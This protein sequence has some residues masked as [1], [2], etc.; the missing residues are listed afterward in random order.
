[1]ICDS[2]SARS[3]LTA[4]VKNTKATRVENSWE[5]RP[6]GWITAATK[7]TLNINW[8]MDSGLS[9]KWNS[10][11]IGRYLSHGKKFPFIWRVSLFWINSGWGK[12]CHIAG[13][14][15]GSPVGSKCRM[16]WTESWSSTWR[17]WKRTGQRFWMRYIEKKTQSINEP[18]FS[19]KTSFDIFFSLFKKWWN[20]WIKYCFKFGIRFSTS[21]ARKKRQNYHDDTPFK[22][23]NDKRNFKR[24]GNVT[25]SRY[26]TKT[27]R[28]A[29]KFKRS[30]LEL[31]LRLH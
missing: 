4:S 10:C 29:I 20:F 18:I 9:R 16:K 30:T 5:I 22:N 21:F 31:V 14:L 12:R 23:Y 8:Q 15:S 17:G 19:W 27:S 7:T 24:S 6:F 26:V 28:F 11:L 25:T 3:R 1:M 13:H 2:L